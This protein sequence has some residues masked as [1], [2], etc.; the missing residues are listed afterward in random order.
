MC[1]CQK[2]NVSIEF[3][4]VWTQH[5][6]IID[7]CMTTNQYE[8]AMF[9]FMHICV[10]DINPLQIRQINSSFAARIRSLKYVTIPGFSNYVQFGK[11]KTMTYQMACQNNGFKQ[12]VARFE[13]AL[14][15][16]YE[17]NSDDHDEVVKATERLCNVYKQFMYYYTFEN[18]SSYP[19]VIILIICLV[20]L[21]FIV[22]T[23]GL[24]LL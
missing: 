8:C 5:R 19:I 6:F 3:F 11:N 17:T 23:L 2:L 16:G 20:L 13:N 18:E 7:Y 24:K 12:V 14:L 9:M 10:L 4:I 1:L 22:I 15:N 21:L